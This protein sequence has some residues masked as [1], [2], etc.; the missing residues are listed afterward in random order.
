MNDPVSYIRNNGLQR[1]GVQTALQEF[2]NTIDWRCDGRDSV[3]DAGCGPGDVTVDILMPI[4]PANF[5]RLVGVDISESMI[6]YARKAYVRPKLSFELFDLSKN[7]EAQTFRHTKPF[8]HIFSFYVI[9]WISN[10]ETCIRNFYKLLVPNGEILLI[11]IGKYPVYD[12]FKEQSLNKRWAK[13]MTDFDD[14]MTPF[15]STKYLNENSC[16]LLNK[17]GFTNCEV[18]IHRKNTTYKNVNAVR[19]ALNFKS[20]ALL[21]IT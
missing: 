1:L 8:D 15:S 16:D 12:T 6:D 2:A 14:E 13:Y 9:M 4:L 20:F 17:H 21:F 5:S 3:L 10:L 11:T 18:R 19:G 7:L